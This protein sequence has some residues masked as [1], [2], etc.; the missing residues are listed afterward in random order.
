MSK[1]E[2]ISNRRKTAHARTDGAQ[3]EGVQGVL[4]DGGARLLRRC[5]AEE[6]EGA[7][8][9]RHLDREEL[10]VLYAVARCSR[11]CWRA[12]VSRRFWRRS[13]WGLRWVEG[14]PQ[15]QL[16]LRSR[17]STPKCRQPRTSRRNLDGP[18]P[19]SRQ[20]AGGHWPSLPSSTGITVSRVNA[21][22]LP[23][24]A[25]SAQGV[26]ARGVL[27]LLDAVEAAGMDMHSLMVVRHS[28]VVA[29]GWW[30]PYKADDIQE[31]YSLSK[32]FT[33]TAIGIAEGEGSCR[34]T[35]PWSASSRT[36]CR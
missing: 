4:G 5:F 15:C 10:R 35:T 6:A 25:P 18:P 33:S 7:H 14:R 32:S 11:P 13:R 12:P 9:R 20:R 26:D 34:S 16:G 1:L 21:R 8:R 27:A 30:A 24:S 29:E 36:R 28:H 2:D 23:R 3:L 22:G 17:C 31:M 19:C